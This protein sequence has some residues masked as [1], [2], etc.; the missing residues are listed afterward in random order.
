MLGK[1]ILNYKI[2]SLIGEGGMGNVYLGEHVS[3]GRKVAIKVLK[4]ELVKN[5]Q[6]RT[7]FKNEASVMAHLQHPNI[8]NL[9][10]YLETEDGLFLVMEYVDGQ[11]IT[12][13]LRSLSQPLAMERARKIMNSILDAFSYAHDAGI[14]HRDVKPSNILID[15]KDNVKILDFGIAKLIGDSQFNLTKTGV[16]IGTIYYMSPEQVKAKDVDQRTDIYSLGVTFYEI[17]SGQCP[18]RGMSSEFEIYSDIVNKELPDLSI[19]M[20]PDYKTVWEVIRKATAKEPK[21]RFQSCIE[22]KNA[23]NNPSY[24]FGNNNV[25]NSRNEVIKGTSAPAR[26]KSKMGVVV[27]ISILAV[28]VLSVTGYFVYQNY[29]D[30]QNIDDSSNSDTNERFDLCECYDLKEQFQS[31]SDAREKVGD[32]VVDHCIQLFNSATREDKENCN[33]FQDE[34]AVYEETEIEEE[35]YESTYGA[36]TYDDKAK[37]RQALINGGIEDFEV[38]NCIIR[39]LEIEYMSFDDADSRDG[40]DEKEDRLVQIMTN[41]MN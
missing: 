23:L 21:D 16:Q 11:E 29:F 26:R 10:D 24:S 6:I 5:E 40:G 18:Y 15:S 38:Q 8:V 7:R 19:A 20:G 22:F 39:A 34:E 9:I 25:S 17:F 32:E 3:I 27:L 4:S 37:A 2:I 28:A 33:N 1:T 14:I 35:H 30:R 31:E 36:W 12:Q 13:L 41:C